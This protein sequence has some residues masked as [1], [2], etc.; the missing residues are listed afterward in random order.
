[1][2]DKDFERKLDEILGAEDASDEISA[3]GAAGEAEAELEEVL[4]RLREQDGPDEEEDFD[5][6]DLA[7]DGYIENYDY[8]A[9]TLWVALEQCSGN[10]P[11]I[12]SDPEDPDSETIQCVFAVP[13]QNDDG[14]DVL[15]FVFRR[16]SGEK[17]VTRVSCDEDGDIDRF[18]EEENEDIAKEVLRRFRAATGGRSD[19]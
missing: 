6:E 12:A 14:T 4:S 3:D 7:D 11:L 5:D 18:I 2:K 19:R 10:E 17:L 16:T 1:M 9:D 15:Y 13:L 8:S